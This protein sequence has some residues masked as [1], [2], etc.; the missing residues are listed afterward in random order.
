MSIQFHQLG[1]SV[2]YSFPFRK[3]RLIVEMFKDNTEAGRVIQCIFTLPKPM[4][5]SCTRLSAA[6]LLES[7]SQTLYYSN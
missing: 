5:I 1:Q 2:H 7:K 6:E 3:K 4:L